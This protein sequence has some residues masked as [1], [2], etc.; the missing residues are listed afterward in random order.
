MADPDREIWEKVLSHLRAHE[1]EICR[2]W[3]DDIEPIGVADGVYRLRAPQ[4]V[5]RNYL[6]KHCSEVF[7]AAVQSVTERLLTV[8]F[9]GPMDAAPHHAAGNGHSKTNGKPRKQVIVPPVGANSGPSWRESLPVSPD[10]TFDNFIVGQENRLAHAAA[11]AVARD[12]GCEY[13]PLFIYGG[14]GLG[15]THLLQAIWLEVKATR[16]DANIHYTSA[17]G[18]TTD[19]QAAM[20]SGQLADFRDRVLNLDLLI[21]DD[22]QFLTGRASTREEFFHTFNNL[23]QAGRQIVL[24]SDAPPDDIPD[25]ESRLVSRF[26]SGLVIDV[27]PPVFETRIE[28]L[29]RKASIRG[30]TIPDDAASFIAQHVQRNVRELEGAITR[31]QMIQQ[32]DG[33][34]LSLESV[35]ESL[36]ETIK[37]LKPQVST[38]QLIA[39]VTDYFNVRLPD[40][41]SKRRQ[42]SIAFPR[43]VAM[44]LLRQHT[45]FS[46]EEIGG[47][48]GGRDHTTVMHAVRTIARKRTEDETLDHFI[49]SVE[50]RF[51]LDA[52]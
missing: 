16:P 21:I 18:F 5:H 22:I 28:I 30:L 25:L 31:L 37:E 7:S 9:I 35:R 3:F 36:G 34:R 23:H 49:E 51:G 13:N 8:R 20:Q 48:F 27:R 46:L 10:H 15:K 6:E 29:K 45:R 41:Q 17:E 14:V 42:K 12:A 26:K 40:L 50:Q 19:L 52:E 4:D 32:L 11:K 47:Y 39:S 24:S 38:D 1:H 43:Q 2:Q 33:R 44:Y